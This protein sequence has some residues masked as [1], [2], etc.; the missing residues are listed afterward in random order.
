[1]AGRTFTVVDIIEICVH[2]YACL[3]VAGRRVAGGG[4]Q[5]GQEVP[6]AGRGGWDRPR[7]PTDKKGT[8]TAKDC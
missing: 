2:W 7:K 3:E 6:G 1:M 8:A 5:D 4:S